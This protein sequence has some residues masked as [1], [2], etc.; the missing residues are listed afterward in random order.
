MGVVK[1]LQ[2][3]RGDGVCRSCGARIVWAEVAGSGKR[4]PFD[5]PLAAFR[6]VLVGDHVIEEIDTDIS[7][8]H[9]ATCPDAKDWRRK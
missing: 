1:I 3:T 4:M 8:S 2:E 9:F 7:K 5:A 6:A